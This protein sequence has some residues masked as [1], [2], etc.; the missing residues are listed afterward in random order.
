MGLVSG[1]IGT[2]P[3]NPEFSKVEYAGRYNSTLIPRDT[4]SS[5]RLEKNLK[6]YFLV[7]VVHHTDSPD[8][9]MENLK[10]HVKVGGR[11]MLL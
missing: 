6:K 4:V 7:G 10:R 5:A 1:S 8:Q 9:T 2:P 3:V 11:L